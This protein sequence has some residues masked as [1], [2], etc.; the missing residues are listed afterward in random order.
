MSS[1]GN[2]DFSNN[3]QRE[4]KLSISLTFSV[5]RTSSIAPKEDSQVS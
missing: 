1:L 4:Y 5:D 3:L 2:F